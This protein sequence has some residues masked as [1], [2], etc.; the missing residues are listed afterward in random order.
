MGTNSNNINIL[1][2]KN[3]FYLLFSLVILLSCEHEKNTTPTNKL[4]GKPKTLEITASNGDGNHLL[5]YIY[6]T[7]SGVFYGL[8]SDSLQITVSDKADNIVKVRIAAL[9]SNPA[10]NATILYKV[11]MSD[12]D[13]IETITKVD[14]IA[15][16]ETA[17]YTMHYESNAVDT[18]T[19][20]QPSNLFAN[21]IT[22]YN[23]QYDGN[24]YTKQKLLWYS[25]DLVLGIRSAEDSITYTY[26]T[27]PNNN[28]VPMQIPYLS[29]GYAITGSVENNL[30]LYALA[31]KGYTVF[32]KNTYLI[33]SLISA[34]Y[35][36]TINYHYTLNS[37]NQV[38]EL[39]FSATGDAVIFNSYKLTY[40]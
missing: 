12:D 29:A 23:Y 9:S 2:M 31:L 34:H 35:N 19:D 7:A 14:T 11:Y 21:N 4:E 22:N 38:S 33:Q 1:Y 15:A 40:Y 8:V 25:L 26:T 13:R 27:L 24:N 28:F 20:V 36:R 30:L 10:F 6:D 17:A 39:S 18:F 16:E 5:Y 32:R 3:L 37:L